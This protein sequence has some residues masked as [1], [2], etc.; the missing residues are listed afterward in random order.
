MY[1]I[2]MTIVAIV[3]VLSVGLVGISGPLSNV[4]AQT[5]STSGSSSDLNSG[6]AG[7]A[8]DSSAGISSAT[9]S[10]VHCTALST[11]IIGVSNCLGYGQ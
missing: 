9:G 11:F 5:V 7:Y 2:I 3:T 8:T 1:K 10:T 6:S 4:Y